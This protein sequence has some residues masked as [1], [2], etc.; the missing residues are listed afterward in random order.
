MA[1]EVRP[2]H[3]GIDVSKSTLVIANDDDSITEIANEAPA[4]RSWLKNLPGPARIGVEATGVFHVELI[5]R[6]HQAGH[7]VYV[8]DGFK[9]NRYRDSVG[10]RAK[11][12]ASDAQLLRRYLANE[13]KQLRPWSPP[14]KGYRALQNL[15]LRRAKL[16]QCRTRIDQSLRGL[17]ELGPSR[18]ALL[19]QIDQLDRMIV[20]RIYKVLRSQQWYTEAKNVQG[21]EGIGDLVSAA[22]VMAFHRC[23]FRSSDAFIAFIGLDVRIKDS[24]TLKGRRKLT[25]KGSPELRRLLY[26]AAMTASRSATWKAFYQ[27][28]LDRGLAT[29]EALIILA[30]KLARIAFTLLKNGTQYQPKSARGA[31]IAT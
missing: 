14:P 28:H 5:E 21:I 15:L 9:L 16:V 7:A 12:D 23:R 25:K 2:I 24:G 19:R 6:A 8:I 29:T 31:C 3:I 30:R 10:G 22:L 17:T 26:L 27:R 1:M 4:I 20:R 13:L 11:T 18:R